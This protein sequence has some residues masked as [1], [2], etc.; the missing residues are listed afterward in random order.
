M[1]VD[2]KHQGQGLGAALLKHFMLK[3]FEVSQLIGVRLVLVH[4]KD[5][6]AREFYERYGFAASPIDPLILFMRI[7]L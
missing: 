4:A 5:P 7:R 1:A 2:Q 3:A 6:E